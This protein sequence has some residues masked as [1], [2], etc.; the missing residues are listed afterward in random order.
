MRI[1][2]AILNKLSPRD[3][4]LAFLKWQQQVSRGLANICPEQTEFVSFPGDL[5]VPERFSALHALRSS[6]QHKKE[7]EGIC[8]GIYPTFAVNSL[9]VWIGKEALGYI[10]LSSLFLFLLSASFCSLPVPYF[11]LGTL[12]PICCYQVRGFTTLSLC[13]LSFGGVG[14]VVISS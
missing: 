10:V 12:K 7:Q 8:L 5:H 1:I 13:G 6:A 9:M 2:A 11:S 3:H 4:R 14:K